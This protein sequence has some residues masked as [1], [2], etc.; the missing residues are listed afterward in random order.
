MR[1]AASLAV[2]SHQG[3]SAVIGIGRAPG[4][5]GWETPGGEFACCQPSRTAGFARGLPSV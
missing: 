2:I 4:E 5:K 1:D 3:L